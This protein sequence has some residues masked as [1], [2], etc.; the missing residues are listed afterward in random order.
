[1]SVWHLRH[2]SA[3]TLSPSIWHCVQFDI[4]SRLACGTERS[5]GEICALK[6][7]ALRRKENSIS[8]LLNLID[9]QVQIQFLILIFI[10]TKLPRHPLLLPGLLILNRLLKGWPSPSQP[11]L[12][13][14]YGKNQPSGT[15]FFDLFSM[16]RLVAQVRPPVN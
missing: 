15:F 3:E 5:P 7:G 8:N 14:R 16:N 2:F 4:P 11:P 9:L 6:P 12:M 1:M 13:S 10:F